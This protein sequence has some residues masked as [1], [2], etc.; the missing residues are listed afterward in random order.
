MCTR[1][2]CLGC[3]L[4]IYFGRMSEHMSEDHGEPPS[5]RSAS[6]DEDD[7]L[8]DDADLDNDSPHGMLSAL[9]D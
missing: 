9:G 6:D 1:L 7:D 3:K 8:D 5:K 4:N 2:L